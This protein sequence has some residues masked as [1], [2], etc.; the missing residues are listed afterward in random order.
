M[1]N[2]QSPPAD[3]DSTKPSHLSDLRGYAEYWK[4]VGPILAE[5]ERQE[6][7]A[8]DQRS[9]QV[10]IRDLLELA[11]TTPFIDNTSGL[12]EWHRLL[13]KLPR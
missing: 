10:A 9:R 4:R 2:D 6:L 5:V 8:M 13:A 11:E 3:S 7:L 12:V 1:P